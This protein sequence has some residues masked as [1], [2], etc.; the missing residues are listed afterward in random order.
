MKHSEY[1]A[2]IVGTGAAGLYAALKIS[3]QI[4]LPDGVLLITK[5]TLGESNSKYAQGGIVGVVHQNEGDSVDMHVN[6]TIKA[7]AGLSDEKVARYISEISDDVIN[8]LYFF[9]R[10]CELICSSVNVSFI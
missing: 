8:D 10:R 9:E 7:G 3:Q 2:I 5:S 1:S 6:D 4:S